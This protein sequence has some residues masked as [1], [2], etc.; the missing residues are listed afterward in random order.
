V[1]A[2][3]ADENFPEPVVVALRGWGHDV[4]MARDDGRSGQRI[5]DDSVLARAVEL[6]RAILTFDRRDYGRLH[7]AS[8]SH[9]GIFA[10][11]EDT[12]FAA[13]A[14]RIDDAVAA[15]PDLSGIFLRIVRPNPPHA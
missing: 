5:P 10:C 15:H 6:G 3:Y 8:A 1:A 14:G 9:A 7:R 2:F 12:D 11:T 13:L 4:L